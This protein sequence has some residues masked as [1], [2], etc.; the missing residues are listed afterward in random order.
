MCFPEEEALLITE[1][2]R[3]TW[4][5]LASEAQAG[6]SGQGA[7][8]EAM[9]RLTDAVDAFSKSSDTYSHRMFWLN[10]ILLILTVVQAAAVIKAWVD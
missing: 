10:I 3:H 2:K 8:V 6:L 7:V 5:Q 9:H 4:D 1:W